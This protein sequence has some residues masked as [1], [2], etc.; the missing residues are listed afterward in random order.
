MTTTLRWPLHPAPQPIEALSAWIERLA[1][2][3]EVTTKNLL[4]R[5]LGLHDLPHDLD[6]DPPMF[7]LAELSART[8]TDIARLRAMTLAG[9]VPVLTDKLWVREFEIQEAFDNHIR[10]HSV[11]FKPGRAKHNEIQGGGGVRG[12]VP[13]CPNAHCADPAP[14]AWPTP[15][16]ARPWSGGFR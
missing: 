13:G 10:G 8:G 15:P 11:L 9:W 5:S 1:A 16:V 4:S 2:V 6:H 7:L 14:C 12:T 3:Y